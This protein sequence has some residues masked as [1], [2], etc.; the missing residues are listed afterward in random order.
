M[1]LYSLD[2]NFKEELSLDSNIIT[3]LGDKYDLIS[4]ISFGGIPWY[5]I[6]LLCYPDRKKNLRIIK[7]LKMEMLG[8]KRKIVFPQYHMWSIVHKKLITN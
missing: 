3:R 5:I 7:N 1:Q 6:W 8:K 2:G 4:F